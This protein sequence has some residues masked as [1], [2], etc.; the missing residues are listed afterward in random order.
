MA[1][2]HILSEAEIQS[3]LRELK[4]W[5]LKGRAIEASF[6][7]PTFGDAI[8]LIVQVAIAAEAL[9]HH[10]EMHNSYNRVSFSLSTHDAG[11]RITDLDIKAASRISA[12]ARRFQSVR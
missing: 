1:D 10:P 8:A 5:S 9:G 6:A 7:L 3:A 4:D 12:A 11:D 2:F